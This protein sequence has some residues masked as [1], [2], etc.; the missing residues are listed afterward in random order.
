M[1][2]S[3][4]KRLQAMRIDEETRTLLRELRP[5]VEPHIEGIIDTAFDEIMRH[6]EVRQAYRDVNI[7]EAKKKQINHWIN[8][9]FGAKFTD[10]DFNDSIEMGRARQR[11]GLDLMWYFVFW[12]FVLSELN[13]RILPQYRKNPERQAKVA[14]TMTRVV[15]F[16]L[17]VFNAVYIDSANSAAAAHLSREAQGFEAQVSG[18]VRRLSDSVQDLQH[19]A[20]TLKDAAQ[21]N[22]GRSIDALGAVDEAGNSA[23]TVAAA[24]EEL[25]A[26]IQEIGRQVAQSTDM[27]QDAVGEAERANTMVLG[28]VDT[29]NRIGA[30]LK[31]INSIAS[32]TNLLALNA[33]IE[34]ARAGEAGKG[35]AVVAGE[36]KNLA[37]QTAKATDEISS[38]IAAVQT[39]TRD[40]VAA[41]QGIGATI[42]R[43]SSIATTIAGAVEEQRAA[44]QEIAR[45]VQSVAHSTTN[46]TN[47]MK[48]VSRL[49]ENTEGAADAVKNKI[50]GVTNDTT[51]LRNEIERFLS[52]IRR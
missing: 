47:S 3:N 45:T 36:V 44:T 20:Q 25:A 5:L 17:E 50:D 19:T 48:A 15:M 13:R 8:V 37:N 18:V 6:E 29:A 22:V 12:G 40:A 1:A 33:T 9:I 43:V 10:D 49:T 24:T 26:S 2:L 28:L 38:Q 4:V 7:A 51:T 46:A 32:Q 42:Q 52:T 27:T 41:I 21:E 31:L 39:A 34:A 14:A 16:D 30:V 11:M 35:F 23:Q